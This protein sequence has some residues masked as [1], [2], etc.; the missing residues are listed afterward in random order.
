MND[1]GIGSRALQAI[2]IVVSGVIWTR[3]V[4][5]RAKSRQEKKMNFS[6]TG[7]DTFRLF[8]SLQTR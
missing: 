5:S 4:Y 2:T 3:A 7:V 1:A 8:T 6:C